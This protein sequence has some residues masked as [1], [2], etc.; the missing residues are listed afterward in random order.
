MEEIN[1]EEP[2][3]VSTETIQTNQIQT[4]ENNI[5]TATE[6]AEIKKPP[7]KKESQN[8]DQTQIKFKLRITKKAK[9]G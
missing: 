6:G 4:S 9:V 2:I 3:V 8:Q 5:E 7:F 1:K